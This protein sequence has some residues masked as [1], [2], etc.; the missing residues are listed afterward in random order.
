[1]Q[2]PDSLRHKLALFGSS[3]KVFRDDN[4]LFSEPSW[5]AVMV[6]QGLVPSAYHPFVDNRDERGL[7][8]LMAGVRG[9]IAS[10]VARQPLHRDYLDRQC[11]VAGS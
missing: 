11:R 5:I 7:A 3:G 1:M 10:L 2:V 8:E 4:E 9:G 6:G